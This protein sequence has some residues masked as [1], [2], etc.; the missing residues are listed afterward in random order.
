[1]QLTQKEYALLLMLVQHE[2]TYIHAGVL[3][4]AVWKA[5]LVGDGNALW[6]QVSNLK[7]KLAP[8]SHWIQLTVSRGNGYCIALYERGCCTISSATAP[9]HQQTLGRFGGVVRSL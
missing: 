5:P 7:K 6:K 8:A 4:E 2:G 1:M 3:Y 9:D